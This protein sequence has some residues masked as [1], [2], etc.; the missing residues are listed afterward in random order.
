MTYYVPCDLSIDTVTLNW[1]GIYDLD[2]T[3]WKYTPAEKP[4]E[5]DSFTRFM[6]DGITVR[7]YPCCSLVSTSFSASR[8][9][10]KYNCY[11]Y[12]NDQYDYVKET[13]ERMIQQATE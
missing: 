6:Q 4:G 3:N 10:N 7:Y 5:M 8:V 12:S 1:Y 11:E 9:A 2:T 13:V